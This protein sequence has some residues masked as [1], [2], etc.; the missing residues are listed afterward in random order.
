MAA[1]LETMDAYI[2]T[3]PD[4]VQVVIEDIRLTIRRAAPSAVEAVKYGMPAFRMN[5][6]YL[7]YVAAWKSHIGLYPVHRG[8]AEFEAA[9][10]PYRAEKDSVKF[11]LNLPVPHDIIVKIIAARVAALQGRY[12]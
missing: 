1:K 7:I 5:D 10:A 8:D 3:L 6:T 4:G 2:A 9:L 12:A 11:M